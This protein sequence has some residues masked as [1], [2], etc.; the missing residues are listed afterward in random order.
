MENIY[1]IRTVKMEKHEVETPIGNDKIFC[2]SQVAERLINYIGD[3]TQERLVAIYLDTKNHIVAFSDV[4]TGSDNKTLF[5]VRSILQR[6]LLIN[7]NSIIIGHNHPSGDTDPSLEDIRSTKNLKQVMD[8]M[9][10]QL[11]DHII[12]GKNSYTSLREQEVI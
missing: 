2:S 12:V 5:P 6:M 3:D 4:A 8:I 7:T 11:L 1:E 10:A 9:G